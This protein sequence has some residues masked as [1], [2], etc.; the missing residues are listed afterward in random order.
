M[1]L[2]YRSDVDGPERPAGLALPPDPMP[3]WRAGRPLKRWR[4]I[5]AFSEDMM[6]CVGSARIGPAANAWWAA[7]DR[8]TQRLHGRT[9]L[10]R[11][12]VRF[13]GASV[14]VLDGDVAIE[15]RVDEGAA[16][17]TVCRVGETQA[18]TWTSKQAGRPVRGRVALP[19]APVLGLRGLAVVDDSAGY[20]PRHTAWH[21]S[22][23]VGES[24]DGRVVGWNLVAGIND[25][26]QGS[27]R[28]V[29]VDGAPM[30]AAPVRFDGLAGID[31]ADGERLDFTPEATRE[32]RDNLL[33]IRSDYEQPFGT[34]AGTLPGGVGLSA[35]MGVMERHDARW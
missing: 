9:W 1:D 4:Y 3:M 34:F 28:S 22:A 17:E 35:A 15:L 5:A 32:R 23:G 31:G 7:W 20:H 12:G 19:D 24:T 14:V 21:W 29:W 2:P 6:I 26:P 25:P 16:V 10:R 30:E 11:G 13:D 18:Y 8:R 33:L 27:E